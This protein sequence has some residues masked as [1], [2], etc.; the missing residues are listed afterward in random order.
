M[1]RFAAMTRRRHWKGAMSALE[2][3]K[4]ERVSLL[5][6]HEHIPAALR[7]EVDRIIDRYAHGDCHIFTSAAAERH[8]MNFV[9][10]RQVDGQVPVHSCLAVGGSPCLYL[11]AYGLD[12][13]E[14]IKARYADYG[15]L[16]VDDDSDLDDLGF[17]FSP[18]KDDEDEKQEREDALEALQ[19][20][21]VL[22]ATLQNLRRTNV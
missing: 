5:E 4:T 7:I 14:S 17:M 1:G 6:Q 22:I 21:I 20:V 19:T 12:T 18:N 3:L 16:Y 13:I 8:E 15:T 11:D 2:C 10:L 9:I